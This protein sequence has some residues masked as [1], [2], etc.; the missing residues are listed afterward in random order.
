MEQS[1]LAIS[2]RIKLL[3]EVRLRLIEITVTIPATVTDNRIKTILSTVVRLTVRVGCRID[4]C[5]ARLP[6]DVIISME[7]KTERS[8]YVDR[9]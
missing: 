8:K 2:D 3:D 4:S 7:Q 9:C 5:L 1:S 6:I